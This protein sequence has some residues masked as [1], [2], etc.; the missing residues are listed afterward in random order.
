MILN[1]IKTLL[2]NSWNLAN[3]NNR[4]PS[5]T[6]IFEVKRIE[7]SQS[8]EDIILL[9]EL[10]RVI[11]DNGSGASSK[12]ITTIITI[13]LRTY[14]REQLILIRNE[15][16]RILNSNQ[17]NPFSDNSYEISDI[18]DERDLSDKF[19]KLFRYQINVKFQELNFAV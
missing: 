2:D 11:Q 3:T 6:S 18:T 8:G 16:E 1:K 14:S 13:D 4:T 5:V 12:Q 17:V 19:I 9:D 7:I 10:T 15:I